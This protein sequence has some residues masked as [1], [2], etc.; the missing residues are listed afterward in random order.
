MGVSTCYLEGPNCLK[1]LRRSK[2]GM[3]TIIAE[4]MMVLIVITMSAILFVFYSVVFGALYWATQGFTPRI[5][6]S[7]P[8]IQTGHSYYRSVKLERFS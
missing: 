1:N 5:S 4:A 2:R 8:R 6:P 3:N 7:S